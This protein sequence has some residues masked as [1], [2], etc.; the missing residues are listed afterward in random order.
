[1]AKDEEVKT[2]D[3]SLKAQAAAAKKLTVRMLGAYAPEETAQL[4]EGRFIV[5][6]DGKAEIDPDDAVYFQDTFRFSMSA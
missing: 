3:A 2:A 4:P 5:F 1:M 6:K